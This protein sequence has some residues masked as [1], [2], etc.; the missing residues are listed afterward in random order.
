M[1]RRRSRVGVALLVLL[2]GPTAIATYLITAEHPHPTFNSSA[3]RVGAPPSCL[4]TVA[5]LYGIGPGAGQDICALADGSLWF[6]VTITNTGHAEGFALSCTVR[7]LGVDGRLRLT[8]EMDVALTRFPQG[9]QVGPGET[10]TFLWFL[11]GV[12]AD[13]A[14]TVSRYEFD[15]PA[16][17]GDHVPF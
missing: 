6:D 3:R 17:D 8:E 13:L 2:A 7:G 5:Q 11:S 16:V 1:R 15:C 9:Q 12:P 10:K 14:Q 4:S